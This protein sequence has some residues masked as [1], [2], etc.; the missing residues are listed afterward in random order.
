MIPFTNIKDK[1]NNILPWDTSLLQL[2]KKISQRGAE[3]LI[4]KSKILP[5]P[6]KLN[7][8]LDDQGNK[9]KINLIKA[10]IEKIKKKRNLVLFVQVKEINKN[11]WI[12]F[13]ND[14]RNGRKWIW[15]KGKNI[16]HNQIIKYCKII[17]KKYKNTISFIPSGKAVEIFN[18]IKIDNEKEEFIRD[19]KFRGQYL[20]SSFKQYLSKGSSLKFK[21]STSKLDHLDELE[22]ES[23]HIIR[24]VF[25][26]AKNPVMLY[27]IGKDS[28]VMLHLAAKAFFPGKIPFKLMHVDTGWKFQE[29]Y[30]FRDQTIK[31]Y[32]VDMIVF[33][34]KEG[35]KKNINPFDD[36]SSNHT[37][38]M[39]TQALLMAIDK[40][41]FDIAFGGARR[42]E[43]K[44]RAKERILSF[45]NES[46]QW[47]PKNQ[48]PELWNIYNTRINNNQSIRAFPL[49]NWTELDIWNYILREKIEIVPLYFAQY[50]PVVNY[51]GSLIMVDDDRIDISN[52]DVK[53]K[54][55]RFRTL[56]CYPLT[57]AIESAADSVE[58]IVKELRNSN[59]SERQGRVIDNDENSSMEKKKIEGYF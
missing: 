26:E 42:D 37:H 49:S 51:N 8:V 20:K 43:E 22:S 27:S 58:L 14:Q 32:D 24:E 12:F 36:G 50:R 38:I 57:G 19:G 52:L 3:R 56:G 17:I 34:N 55:I 5:K 13:T 33:Q 47:D 23:I 2:K 35:L 30:E 18:N 48:R 7:D 40:Y 11:Q 15:H 1:R 4:E 53:I 59:F 21:R 28:A 44:S 9:P 31:K 46:H 45:R 16:D 41:K 6:I 10:H 54:K 29:M 39:K 25:A